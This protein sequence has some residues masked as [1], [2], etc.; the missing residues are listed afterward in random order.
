MTQKT[1]R[2]ARI[3]MRTSWVTVAEARVQIRAGEKEM[4]MV[5]RWRV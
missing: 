1:S 3:F 4:L 5:R 2:K